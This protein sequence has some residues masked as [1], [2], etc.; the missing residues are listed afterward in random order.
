MMRPLLVSYSDTAGGAAR[1]AYRIHTAL[2]ASGVQSELAVRRKFSSDE[3]VHEFP[4]GAAQALRRLRPRLQS[5]VQRLQ[6]TPNP[7]LHSSNLAPS[8]WGR[9]LSADVVNLHWIGAGAMSIEDVAHI[10]APV[11]MTLHDMWAFCGSEHYA[12]DHP[13]ARWV[14]G[15]SPDNRPRGHHGV[16]LDRLTWQRKRRHWRPMTLIAPSRWLADCAHRSALMAGW[17]VHVVPSPLDVEVFRHRDTAEARTQFGLPRDAKV[18][19]FGAI[20]GSADPRKGFDLLLGA[21]RQLDETEGVLG[22]VFGQ[23]EPADPPRPGIPLRWMG[24]LDDDEA[25][26]TLYSAADVMVV[27]SRQEALGQTASEAQACGTPVVAFDA[28]GLSDVVEHGRTGYLANPFE[29]DALARAIAW[30]LDDDHRRARL[31]G[32]ARARAERLWEPKIVVKQYLA[33]Y[34]RTMAAHKP[35]G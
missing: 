33:I 5:S 29:S 23:G 31:G 22:V 26:A 20:G 4:E 2:R 7:V 25:L 14:V 32:A 3:A 34:E 30:V 18:V 17:P 12:S 28:T 9:R 21:L 19:L 8:R 6:R 15:Y 10:D 27:P 24:S 35:E 16:D 13:E 11:V 1:A